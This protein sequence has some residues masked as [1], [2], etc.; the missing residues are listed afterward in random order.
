MF[1]L[2]FKL[3]LPKGKKNSWVHKVCQAVCPVLIQESPHQI[4]TSSG[5]A[6]W[7]PLAFRLYALQLIFH[8]ET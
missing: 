3:S 7:P 4:L 8:T 6:H 5:H 2:I 1:I